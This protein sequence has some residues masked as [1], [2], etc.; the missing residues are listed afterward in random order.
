MAHAKTMRLVGLLIA[1]LAV[2]GFVGTGIVAREVWVNGLAAEGASMR[3]V[4]GLPVA[5]ATL[6]GLLYF[7]ILLARRAPPPPAS[8]KSPPRAP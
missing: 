3:L 6:G 7:A 5:L 4:I 8:G 1:L 2:A